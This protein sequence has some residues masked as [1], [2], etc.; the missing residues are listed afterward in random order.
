MGRQAALYLTEKQLEIMRLRDEEKLSFTEIGRRM[1][2]TGGRVSQVYKTACDKKSTLDLIDKNDPNI[3]FKDLAAQSLSVMCWNSLNCRHFLDSKEAFL[4][5]TDKDISKLRNVGFKGRLEIQKFMKMLGKDIESES[6]PF[7]DEDIDPEMLEIVKNFNRAGVE[8]LFC[9]QG[10]FKD[11]NKG[12]SIPYLNTKLPK[13][14]NVLLALIKKQ[15]KYPMLNIKVDHALPYNPDLE[16][17]Y[18]VTDYI[19][20]IDKALEICSDNQIIDIRVNPIFY[21]LTENVYN[22]PEAYERIFE[23]L[24]KRF[25]NELSQLSIDI[26]KIYR[27]NK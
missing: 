16:E 4:S 26:L 6:F 18:E 27:S 20:K 2:I 25:L 22:D 3:E 12:T 19:N 7:K 24:R 13:S 23:H 15:A 1:G 5:M 17:Y 10:H 8:T 9:C 14:D 11:L 21:N